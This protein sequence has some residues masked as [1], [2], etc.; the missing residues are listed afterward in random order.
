VAVVTHLVPAK[1]SDRQTQVEGLQQQVAD[2]LFENQL[3]KDAIKDLQQR[4][5]DT[6][7]C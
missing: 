4:L 7:K 6:E 3:L 1:K 2:L 5:E